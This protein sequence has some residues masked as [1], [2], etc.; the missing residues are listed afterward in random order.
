MTCQRTDIA[1]CDALVCVRTRVLEIIAMYWKWRSWKQQHS[2]ETTLLS[3][4]LSL[5]VLL[6]ELSLSCTG[7]R[8]WPAHV[9]RLLRDARDR[10]GAAPTDEGADIIPVALSRRRPQPDHRGGVRSSVVRRDDAALP[11]TEPA[12]PAAI[13]PHET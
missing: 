8:R 3:M 7:R 11:G 4:Q 5:R 13:V 2:I 1:Q 10:P 12:P 9:R 6:F